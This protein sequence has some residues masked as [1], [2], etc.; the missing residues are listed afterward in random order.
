MNIQTNKKSNWKMFSENFIILTLDFVFNF[1]S[2]FD[3][4]R[5]SNLFSP[6]EPSFKI[7]GLGILQ[8]GDICKITFPI[9]L[10]ILKEKNYITIKVLA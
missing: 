6:F 10:N 9:V 5:L 4:D 7:H 2:Y 3:Y 1:L 8:I